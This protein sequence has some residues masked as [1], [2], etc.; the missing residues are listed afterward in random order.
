MNEKENGTNPV[1]KKIGLCLSGGGYRAAGYHLGTMDYLDRLGLLD[2]VTMLSTVSGGTFI[3]TSYT[4]SLIEKSSFHNYLIDAYTFLKDA[5]YIEVLFEYLGTEWHDRPG[6]RRNLIQAAAEMYAKGFLYDKKNE[7]PYRF[8]SI[9]NADNIPL[10][11]VIFNAT[12]FF[13]GLNYKFQNS[14]K[15]V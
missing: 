6:K 10:H 7:E 4:I 2:K 15:I 11:T 5:G 3:G 1:P 12:C 13:T 9:V 8:E 14:K